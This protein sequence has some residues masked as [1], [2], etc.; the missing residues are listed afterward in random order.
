MHEASIAITLLE[1]VIEECKNN[2]CNLVK[3]VKI[4]VGRA[5]GVMPDALSFVFNA[6]KGDTIASNA[7]LEINET[8]LTARCNQCSN[9][10][11]TNESYIFECPHCNSNT[12]IILRGKELNIIEIEVE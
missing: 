4:E 9:E 10:F 1:K 6:I 12:F 11:T 2:G 3:N 7:V 5:S 8:L